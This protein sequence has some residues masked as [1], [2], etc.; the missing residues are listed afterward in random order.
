MRENLKI[1][2]ASIYH[3]HEESQYRIFIDQFTS[4]LKK[5]KQ[6]AEKILGQDI[7]ANIGTRDDSSELNSIIGPHG[8]DNRNDKGVWA[9]QMLALQDLKV[10]NTFF[11]HEDYTTHTSYLPPSLPQMLDV[12]SVS[13]SFFKRVRDCTLWEHSIPSDHAGIICKFSITSISFKHSPP[14]TLSAGEVDWEKIAKDD[15]I[16][17]KFNERLQELNGDGLTNY[18]TFMENIM[19]AGE[20][21][22]MRIKAPVKGWFEENREELQPVIQ[23]KHELLSKMRA[24]TGE[25][26]E[27]LRKELKESSEKVSH[28]IAIAKAN[29]SRKKAIFI[30]KICQTPRQ[31]WQA[32]KELIAGDSCHHNKPVAMKMKMKNGE[33]ASNDKQNMEV[34]EEHLNKVYN[35]K[36]ERF[37]G[38][39]KMVKQREEFSELDH[40]IT[41]KEF[42]KAIAKLK[43]GKAPGT[44]G[45]PPDAFK[46]LDGDNHKQIFHYVVDFWEG[47]ANYWEWHTGLGVLVPKKGELSDPNKWRGIN[48]MDVCSKIFSCILNERL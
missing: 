6:K 18:S 39:A 12:I 27:C 45:V 33:L 5:K 16:R 41:M 25:E 8:F 20:D 9:L 21:T 28:Q 30:H 4:L 31:A 37:A 24:S 13:S 15:Q 42:A 38:A 44:T 26:R 2:I 11:E 3:P 29:W 32:I 47:K 46:C 1:F 19:R 22:A 43:N 17:R 40:P 10:A 34:V 7:N 48:L 35:A 23:A 36:R 14:T